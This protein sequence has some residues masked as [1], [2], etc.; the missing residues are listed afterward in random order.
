MSTGGRGLEN[1]IGVKL[2]FMERY[3]IDVPS[4]NIVERSVICVLAIPTF[5]T[6]DGISVRPPI[7]PSAEDMLSSP[8]RNNRNTGNR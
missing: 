5:I 7:N 6:V 2:F 4:R 8:I 1:E 3:R